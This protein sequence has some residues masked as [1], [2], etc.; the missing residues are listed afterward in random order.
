MNMKLIAKKAAK[1]ALVAILLTTIAVVGI[2]LWIVGSVNAR[3]YDRIED[4][5]RRDVALLLG[6][7][8]YMI[9]GGDNPFF[10]HRIEAA[11][12]LFHAGKVRHIIVSGESSPNYNE[13]RAMRKALLKKGV[14]EAAITMDFAGLRTFDSVVRCQKIFQ[15]QKV[16]IISQAF[17]NS[18]ALFI[19]DAY[20]LDAIAYNAAYPSEASSRTLLREYLARPKAVLDL[21][22]LDTQPQYLGEQVVINLQTP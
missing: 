7:S 15:Q 10:T 20:G 12:D 22:F 6:T 8:P 21:Y 19:A 9:G 17:H 16:T 14:P 5:E 2:N 1:L 18:R 3:M 4:I 13:P 11:A